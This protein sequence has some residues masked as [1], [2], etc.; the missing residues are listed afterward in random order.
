MDDVRS[1]EPR[2]PWL[3]GLV[4]IAALGLVAPM[5]VTAPLSQ[6]TPV[7]TAVDQVLSAFD[8]DAVFRQ[9]RGFWGA[10]LP[11]DPVVAPVAAGEVAAVLE[12]VKA[13]WRAVSPAVDGVNVVVADLPDGEVSRVDGSVIV[14][15]ATAGGRG[16]GGDGLDLEAV[17]WDDTAEV[18]GVGQGGTGFSVPVLLSGEVLDPVVEEAT[19]TAEVTSTASTTTETTPTETTATEPV[20]EPVAGTVSEPIAEPVVEPVVESAP[21]PVSEPAPATVSTVSEPTS[22]SPAASETDTAS[23]LEATTAGSEGGSA[24]GGLALATS[25]LDFGRVLPGGE[26]SLGVEVTNTGSATLA[27][28]PALDDASG[29]FAVGPVPASLAPGESALVVVTLSTDAPGLHAASLTFGAGGPVVTLAA[30]VT[31]WAQSGTTATATLADGRVFDHEVRFDG[32]SASLVRVLG[33]VELTDVAPSGVD[34]VVVLGGAGDDRI[35]LAG[36]PGAL[37]VALLGGSGTDTLGGPAVDSTWFVTGEGSGLL[38]G[39]TFAGFENLLGAPGNEDT[40]DVAAGGSLAGVV[41]G[42]AAGF[43]TLVM[44]GEFESVRSVAVD[45]HSGSVL[46]DGRTLVYVGLEPVVLPAAADVVIQLSAGDDVATVTFDGSDFTAVGAGFEQVT[47]TGTPSNSLTVDGLGGTDSVTLSG[48][49]PLG[50]AGFTVLAEVIVLAAGASITTTGDVTLAAAQTTTDVDIPFVGLDPCPGQVCASATVTGS[51]GASVSAA[52]VTITA[53]AAANPSSFLISFADATATVTLTDVTIDSTGAVV[54]AANA[55]VTINASESYVVLIDPN[56]TAAVTIDGA[57]GIEADGAVS[58]SSASTVTSTEAITGLGASGGDV[59]S[60]ATTVV[61]G[62]T[63][64]SSGAATVLSSASTVTSTVTVTP[65]TSA[66]PTTADAAIA[67]ILIDS[68]SVTRLA[69]TAVLTVLGD[70]DLDADNTVTATATGDSSNGT[71][72]GAGVAIIVVT[73]TTEASIVSD[74]SAGAGIQAASLDLDADAVAILSANAT[75]SVG[76]ATANT[77]TPGTASGGNNQTGDGTVDIAGAIAVVDLTGSTLAFIAPAAG[78]TA[79]VTVGTQTIHAGSATNTAAN[80][81]GSTTGAGSTG[82]GVALA[83]NLADLTTEAYVDRS[84]T[85][86]APA[87]VIEIVTPTEEVF[88]ASAKSGIGG[89]NVGVAGALA[90][91][92]FGHARKAHLRGTGVLTLLGAPS[93]TLQATGNR[94]STVTA[95]PVSGGGPSQFGVGASVAYNSAE[96]TTVAGLDAASML[97]GADDLIITATTTD[98]MTTT[99]TGGATGPGNTAIT[100]VVVI[101]ISKVSTSALIDGPDTLVLTIGGDLTTTAQQTAT[102][103]GTASSTA[104]GTDAAVGASLVVV[105]ATH[106]VSST[107]ARDLVAG[108]TVTL[109]ATGTSTVNGTTTALATGAAS[110]AKN[111]NQQAS[112][113][114]GVAGSTNAASLPNAS[115]S[116][117]PIG[118]AAA[119]T[120]ILSDADVVAAFRDGVSVTTPGHAS[121]L[122]AASRTVTASADGSVANAGSVGIGAA[123]AAIDAATS[124]EALLGY[125]TNVQSDGLLMQANGSGA[126]GAG[127]NTYGADATSGAGGTGVAGGLSLALAIIDTRT[128]SWFGLGDPNRGPPSADL[129]SGDLELIADSAAAST[130]SA[131]PDATISG[132]KVGVG[133]SVALAIIN[134]ATT[135]GLA[136]D[137]TLVSAGSLTIEATG[138]H[139]LST[140]AKTGAK[141]AG[142]AVTPA[143]AITISNIE[144]TASTGAGASALAVDGDIALTA[145]LEANAQTV[146]EGDAEGANAAVGIA[147]ALA[148]ANHSATATVERDLAAGGALTVDASADSDV[149]TTASASAAGAPGDDGS[150]PDDGVDQQVAAQRT[151][152][153]GNAPAGGDSGAAATPSAET[154]DGGVSVGAA[155]AIGVVTVAV[156]AGIPAG[157]AVTAGGAATLSRERGVDGHGNR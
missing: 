150:Q 50:T 122:A 13:D 91:G 128:R 65:D 48:A 32:L 64:L 14:L 93:L 149:T 54:I 118:V 132:D 84:V 88:N 25:T 71:G 69:G 146:A 43:D 10:V 41:D 108:G 94:T 114:A 151:W 20:A 78:S 12:A 27:L 76:G 125:G 116:S 136:D 145:D 26:A 138:S 11:G 112:G 24:V 140:E 97:N 62:S 129:G 22:E 83:V 148:F 1:G 4:P 53:T 46:A 73:Q 16:W 109:S 139:T 134:D 99:A 68:V 19:S 6:T 141:S 143:I 144:V 74:T 42:G 105:D 130:V 103:T 34:A 133:A 81:D 5:A 80:A 9:A 127:A 113:Q 37:A 49:L 157:I 104:T 72:G 15:D 156:T 75:S 90:V 77:T 21:E 30:H 31:A 117:G 70:L 47:T 142:T 131:L 55:T 126:G 40:F 98:A 58:V 121:L 111:P 147:I 3:R 67:T 60:S 66:N 119:I 85:L 110:S 155:V 51:G 96:I 101:A 44:R 17:I 28:A 123:V 153:D 115:S 63:A 95:L 124:T 18:L 33:G 52:N 92:E 102:V 23:A 59:D 8:L 152:A 7:E 2:S 89:G 35:T 61:G 87:V 57:S 82:V 38:H 56:A 154:S 29:A 120:I 106:T 39:A 100:P 135:A 36:L 137:A 79:I 107:L 45:A 86:S